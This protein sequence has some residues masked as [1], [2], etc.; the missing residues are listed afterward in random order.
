M[1]FTPEIIDCASNVKNPD[2]VS[3]FGPLGKAASGNSLIWY[4]VHSFEM[5]T[6]LMG[7]G[8]EYVYAR[9]DA[10]GIVSVVEYKGERRGIVECNDGAF[11]YG[12]S[13]RNAKVADTYVTAGSPY[14]HLIAALETFFIDNV[15]PVPFEETLEI[16]AMMDAACK[17]IES[18]EKEAVYK[19]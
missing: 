2:F 16:L 12:G 17:S 1:R 13:A 6:T 15:I 14:P 7:S 11:K 18:G 10:C 19:F 3:I 9:K 8:A 5:L 4:G